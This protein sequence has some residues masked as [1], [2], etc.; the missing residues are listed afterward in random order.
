MGKTFGALGV[1]L[2]EILRNQIDFCNKRF[3]LIDQ[4]HLMSVKL[5]QQE[6]GGWIPMAVEKDDNCLFQSIRRG[7]NIPK[8]YTTRLVRHELGV[9]CTMNARILLEHHPYVLQEEYVKIADE[10]LG[11]VSIKSYLLHILKS[12][13]LEDSIY[14]DM[15]SR[16][17]GLKITVL[18]V[19]KRISSQKGDTGTTALW[20]K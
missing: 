18:D 5:Y 9:Y 19:E 7:L 10:N 13:S 15:I 16:M 2:S 3:H 8:E 4:E 20:I 1:E 6:N 12:K 14:I 17:W 11:P